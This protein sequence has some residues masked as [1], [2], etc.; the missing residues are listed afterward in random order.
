MRGVEKNRHAHL[1]KCLEGLHTLTEDSSE[2]ELIEKEASNVALLNAIIGIVRTLPLL[3]NNWLEQQTHD[4][5][6]LG[7]SPGW[8]TTRES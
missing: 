6:V 2:R 8:S 7:S 1:V 3:V 4:L 5:E